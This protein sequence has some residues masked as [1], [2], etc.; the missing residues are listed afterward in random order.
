MREL[1]I[2]IAKGPR[3]PAC[4]C[5]GFDDWRHDKSCRS[6]GGV[7]VDIYAELK[8]HECGADFEVT[9]FHDGETHS[10]IR[11]EA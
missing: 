11:G 6:G 4:G 10:V 5:D 8:C 2:T 7:V 1:Q 9:H 3:C